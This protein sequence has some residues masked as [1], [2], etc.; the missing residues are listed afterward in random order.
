MKKY[1]AFIF[2][3]A[4][5][6]PTVFA[7]N[8]DVQK[9]SE[10]EVL[11][12]G[13]DVPTTLNFNVT[14]LG[15][16]DRFSF[17]TFFGMGLEPTTS[18]EI[19]KGTSKE[20][21]L[22]IFPR[23]DVNYEGPTTFDIFIQ[24]GDKSETSYKETLNIIPLGE[25]F[26]IGA[27]SINPESNSI[28]IYIKNK[29]NF[30]FE[31]LDVKLTS[32]FFDL[33]K[34]VSL[35]PYETQSFE[36]SLDRDDFSKLV[37]GFYTLRADFELDGI[38]AQVEEQINFLEKNI[39][40]EERND[41]GFVITTTVINKLNE[42]NTVESSRI[43]CEKNIISRL[44]TTFSPEPT[45]VERDG[46]SVTYIW[47]KKLNPGE[48]QKVE[49]RTDWLIPLLIILVVVLTVVL[50]RKYSRMEI[51]VR[52]RVSFINAKGGEFGLKVLI[53][54]EAKKFLENVKIHDRLP[55]LVKVYQKFG[56]EIPK[57]FNKTQRVF[58]WELGNLESGEKRVLSYVIYS[59]IGV[60]GKFALP[61]ATAIFE[62]DGKT[63]H[64]FS[65]R[66]F[67]LSD[68]KSE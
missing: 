46:F 55:P 18:I 23:T 11:I 62:K 15:S 57:R 59:K 56:G 58:E 26:E 52:K 67:F 47:D 16:T 42:G 17:Y 49:V 27:D 51:D 48:T 3:L 44:F 7:V 41:Y 9:L 39:L 33:D 32:P 66:A 36:I 37:A 12:V 28:K 63:K 31:N 35:A 21:E 29:V 2:A 43:T 1:F 22:K 19:S 50:V 65:N 45:L 6:I 54:V 40:K 34:T 5:L 14:N 64:V 60:L 20:V 53:S 30:E 24:G 10:N 8:L 38:S 61:Y 13:L 4:F 68:Q 25:A